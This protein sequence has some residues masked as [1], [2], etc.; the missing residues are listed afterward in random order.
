MLIQHSKV[1]Q[2]RVEVEVAVPP[3]VGGQPAKLQFS[4]VVFEL[5]VEAI[6]ACGK[7]PKDK[8]RLVPHVMANFMT[9]SDARAGSN[10]HSS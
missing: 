3:K 7:A 4:R 2:C 9:I 5:V 1:V 6:N 10:G 8:L